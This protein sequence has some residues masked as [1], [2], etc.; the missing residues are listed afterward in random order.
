MFPMQNFTLNKKLLMKIFVKLN[1]IELKGVE[2]EKNWFFAYNSATFGLN[3]KN[4]T[5]SD[6]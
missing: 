3:V 4:Y 2:I 6:V 5:F 1:T